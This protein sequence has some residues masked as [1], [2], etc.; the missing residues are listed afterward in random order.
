MNFNFRLVVLISLT[1]LISSCAQDS[2]Q[3]NEQPLDNTTP[4]CRALDSSWTPNFVDL[5]LYHNFDGTLGIAFQNGE[6]LEPMIGPTST[7]SNG[8][9]NSMIVTSGKVAQSVSFD[10]LNDYI[11]ANSDTPELNVVGDLTISTWIYVPSFPANSMEI[12]GKYDNGSTAP[13]VFYLSLDQRLHLFHSSGATL[14]ENL[15]TI[16]TLPTNT[17]THV[18]VVRTEN[19]KTIIFY[20]NGVQDTSG[21][22]NYS[23]TPLSNTT[24][25][26]IGSS[27][28]AGGSL[29]G[30][31]MDELAL[32]NVALPMSEIKRIYDNQSGC[33]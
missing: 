31:R 13:F 6:Q 16:A 23:L 15:Q 18:A 10:G 7:I 21:V 24:P 12:I 19:P 17:W 30:G 5:R 9:D 2:S 27:A 14:S 20:I 25:T 32:W 11:T 4:V 29:F 26:R 3:N 22:Q 33:P 1:L 8:T 28:N